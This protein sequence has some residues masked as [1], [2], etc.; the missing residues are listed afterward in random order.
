MTADENDE[1]MNA[2]SEKK[3][4][5]EDSPPTD[6]PAKKVAA[7]EADEEN[8]E[9]ASMNEE[10]EESNPLNDPCLNLIESGDGDHE[11]NAQIAKSE[12]LLEKEEYADAVVEATKVLESLPPLPTIAYAALVR[13]RGLLKQADAMKPE[14]SDEE[15]DENE[16]QQEQQKERH[17]LYEKAWNAFGL[18]NRL[19]PD[20]EDTM[21]EL[22]NITKILGELRPPEPPLD[23]SKVDVDVLIVG[24]GAAGI[25]C[26]LMLTKTFG[27]ENSRVLLVERGASPGET[28]RRWPEEMRFIS[29]S[30]N[31]QGWTD[32]FDLNAIAHGTS[33]AYSL[34]SEHPS[35]IEYAKYLEAIATT[36]E[37]E[38]L[39]GTEVNSIEVVGSKDDFEFKIDVSSCAD[40][41][42]DNKATS[43]LTAR[44]VIWA[45][46][47]FQY[48]R[49]A[50]S[51]DEGGLVGAEHCL[52]NS[53][54]RSWAKLPGDEFIVIGGYESGVDATVNLA[55]AGKKCRVLASTP[56][57]SVKT[58]DPSAEL[59]PYT[60]GRLRD[61]MTPVFS[62]KPELFAPLRV[63][64]VEPSKKGGFDVT[65]EW[66]P[67]EAEPPHAPL[68]DLSNVVEAE[69][70]GK[71]GTTLVLH[72]PNA[73]ILCTGFAGS[74]ATAASN[75]FAFADETH[76]RK[77][78]LG[79]APLLTEDDEST[80]TPGLF[81]AGPTVQH[82][83]LS[84]CFVYKFRQRFAVVA[85]AIC[86]G[87]GLDTKAA[88]AE[89]RSVNMY[90]DD[91]A[92]CEDTCGEVC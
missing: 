87:L 71:E 21:K 55:K 10:E 77:G 7:D 20:C 48:P 83:K 53:Q 38:I 58:E 75:L 35:G 28:F 81:L 8:Q 72:T 60:A 39:T 45:A 86:E 78:C 70:A 90:L 92:R 51:S 11:S 82:D 74:V 2:N 89:C 40:P 29:P 27:L 17:E 79:N 14:K 12:D 66:L 54:V 69:S 13:G 34:H 3:R 4:A 37:L 16:H 88:V 76:A 24:A 84:F 68:R 50:K 1:E 47:E 56:C 91:F 5:S 6:R 44:Y 26:A 31:Q 32:S 46:G 49:N 80:K 52:H 62:P 85:N 23:A 43:S 18:S 22:D 25:G 33:P 9:D 30:F 73:P 63:V 36:N 42:S 64:K 57:W 19:N 65:A 59:A 67:K 41:E 15:K 61:V